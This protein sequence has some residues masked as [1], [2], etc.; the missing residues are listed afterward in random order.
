MIVGTFIKNKINGIG[1]EYIYETF[2]W[3]M[4]RY[5]MGDIIEELAE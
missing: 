1:F 3:T 5:K 4:N 2:T